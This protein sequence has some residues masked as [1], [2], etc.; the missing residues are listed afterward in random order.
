MYGECTK[1]QFIATIISG[2][3]GF[4]DSDYHFKEEGNET[5]LT[6]AAVILVLRTGR[7]HFRTGFGRPR[8]RLRLLIRGRRFRHRGIVAFTNSCRYKNHVATSP[9]QRVR[10]VTATLPDAFN[11]GTPPRPNTHPRQRHIHKCGPNSRHPIIVTV[12]SI[13][14]SSREERLLVGSGRGRRVLARAGGRNAHGGEHCT[15]P[16][17]LGSRLPHHDTVRSS[18]PRQQ[19]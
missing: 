15:Y 8:P 2:I 17:R 10:Q 16:A 1:L 4:W 12:V 6:K 9:K 13:A 11:R 3:L 7:R 5:T 18:Q 14:P 19:E